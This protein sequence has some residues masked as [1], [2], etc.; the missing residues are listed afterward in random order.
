MMRQWAGLFASLVTAV[1]PVSEPSLFP[2]RPLPF[3]VLPCL[4]PSLQPTA[5]FLFVKADGAQGAASHM[6]PEHTIYPCTAL[7]SSACSR[8]S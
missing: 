6:L 2:L 4:R 5:V 1:F 8:S 7:H 3:A